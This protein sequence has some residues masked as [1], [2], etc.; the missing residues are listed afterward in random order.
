MNPGGGRADESRAYAIALCNAV[1][2]ALPSRSPALA[3]ALLLAAEGQ[4]WDIVA[5][6]ADEL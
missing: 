6:I 2:L 5:R 3:K 4:R 1:R